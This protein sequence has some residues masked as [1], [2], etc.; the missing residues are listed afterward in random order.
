MR[1]LTIKQKKFA[2]E[3]IISGNGTQSAI[4]AGY[5]KKT[6]GVIADE[7]LKKPYIASYIANKLK[8]ID[9]KRTMNVKEAIETSSSIARGEVQRSY[10]KKI[11][12]LTGET[13]KEEEY[14]YT[15]KI[16]DRQRSLEHILRCNG[17]F[18]DRLDL[19]SDLSV[20]INF[21]KIKDD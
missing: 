8:K 9:S 1:K 20:K 5:S 21:S 12:K 7:N 6:A 17:A 14:F 19:K 15:P 4:K 11:D 13:L 16:E 2:D 10:S 3:Y 18:L